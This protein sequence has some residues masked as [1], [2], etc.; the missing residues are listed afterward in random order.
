VH[1]GTWV[2]IGTAVFT[3]ETGIRS[4]VAE[5]GTWTGMAHWS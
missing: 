5:S 2:G 4:A 3:R 1:I